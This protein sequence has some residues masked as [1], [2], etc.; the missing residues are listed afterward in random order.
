MDL[1]NFARMYTNKKAFETVEF[2]RANT[3]KT[4]TDISGTVVPETYYSF[5]LMFMCIK[6]D[7]H[8]CVPEYLEMSLRSEIF[9]AES[10]ET[11][12]PFRMLSSIIFGLFFSHKCLFL[13]PS[14]PVQ[15]HLV[16]KLSPEPIFLCKLMCQ[17]P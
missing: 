15:G 16:Y 1:E 11:R 9:L 7:A 6:V 13:R 4:Y 12:A 14:R 3:S 17:S 10:A 8:S 5:V 2:G